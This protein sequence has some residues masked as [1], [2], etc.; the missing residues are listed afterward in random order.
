MTRHD[1]IKLREAIRICIAEL[2]AQGRFTTR[3]LTA[4]MKARYDDIIVTAQ[5]RLITE[6]L[7]SIARQILRDDTPSTRSH[8]LQLPIELAHIPLA[9]ALSLPPI[10][11]VAND[12][13]AE[14]DYLWT[15]TY[16]ATFAELEAHIQ[17]LQASVSADM[18][19][20]VSLRSLYNYLAP[21]MADEHREDAIG[22]VLAEIAKRERA[23]AG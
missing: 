3:E 14:S 2:K 7:A 16:E 8:Q 20:L 18:R 5:D 4:M 1:R 21:I 6:S 15:D 12:E 10:R 9:N 17:F 11:D 19:R 13:Q 23:E 22:P